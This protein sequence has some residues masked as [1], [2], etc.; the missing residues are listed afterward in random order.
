MACFSRRLPPEEDRPPGRRRQKGSG[1]ALGLEAGED[2]F[3]LISPGCSGSGTISVEEGE[4]P[5]E[6]PQLPP[7]PPLPTGVQFNRHFKD[8][9]KRVPI[10]NLV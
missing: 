6:P 1:E 2:P 8:V 9:T 7:P 4:E 5:S 3:D 10:P